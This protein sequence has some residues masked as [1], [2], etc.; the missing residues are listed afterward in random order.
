MVCSVFSTMSTTST[1]SSL[2]TASPLFGRLAALLGC[3]SLVTL[4]GAQAEDSRPDAARPNFV[5]IISDD[6]RWD[7]LGAAGNP[8]IRTPHLDRLAAEGVHFIQATIHVPQC[9]PARAQLLTGLP[10]HQNGWYANQYQRADVKRPDGFG[11]YRLLPA[12]LRDSGY[13]TALVGKWHLAPEP[14]NCGFSEVR[15]WL[16][17]GSGAY[18]DLPLAEGKSRERK[19]TKGFTQEKFADSAVGFLREA[20]GRKEPFFLW[21]AFTAPHTPLKPNP[22]HIQKLYE[23]KTREDLIP[24]GFEGD[25]HP[26]DARHWNHYY[27]AIS[28]LDE[29]VGRVLKTL[30]EE[31]L[32]TR[33]VVVFLG[34][35]GYM[36]GNRGVAGKVVPYEGSV[37]VPLIIRAPSLTRFRGRS[38]AAAS[39]LD[40]PPT[41][42]RMAGLEAPKDWPGRDLLPAL[43]GEKDHG[44]D[45]AVTVFPDNANTKFGDV[46]YRAVRTPRYKLIEWMTESKP[47]EFYDLK[48][49]PNEKRNLA[50]SPEVKKEQ[51]R[52]AKELARWKELTKDDGE[53][54]GIRIV[55]GRGR[56]AARGEANPEE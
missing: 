53:T 28:A 31:N 24:P 7:A 1:S 55:E 21:L 34:D 33:T 11:R 56:R 12:L 52:L 15:T 32:T 8:G 23:G 40:L 30:D 18:R 37:R 38:E 26:R 51:E 3:L 14:W 43:R 50:G 5:F 25:P 17:G 45:F 41:F 49:D 10:P 6:H 35:N 16:P 2:S 39:S 9:S 27:E 54:T 36:M 44:I 4:S 19:P 42:L 22:E 46:G 47:L 13:H 20:A 29:Q 48:A